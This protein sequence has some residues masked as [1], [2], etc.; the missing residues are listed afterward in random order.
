MEEAL[1]SEWV[2]GSGGKDSSGF[3]ECEKEGRS[4]G[5][6]LWRPGEGRVL[7]FCFCLETA[8]VK[9]PR[10]NSLARHW[11]CVVCSG[12]SGASLF[13]LDCFLICF[14]AHLPWAEASCPVGNHFLPVVG[15]EPV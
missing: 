12:W 2:K 4:V 10:H 11:K 8:G 5:Q 9:S 3:K 15:E 6:E 1:R 13:T 7:V 14:S